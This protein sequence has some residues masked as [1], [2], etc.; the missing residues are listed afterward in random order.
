[1]VLF[2]IPFGVLVMED[3]YNTLCTHC[4]VLWVKLLGILRW[5]GHE[6]VRAELGWANLPSVAVEEL[7]GHV[8][9][10][11]SEEGD[12][13][14]TS[15]DLVAQVPHLSALLANIVG[16]AQ[17]GHLIA[18]FVLMCFNKGLELLVTKVVLSLPTHGLFLTI[19]FG[20]HD[21]VHFVAILVLEDLIAVHVI[22]NLTSATHLVILSLHLGGTLFI[23]RWKLSS[24]DDA[25]SELSLFLC[26]PAKLE[27]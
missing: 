25:R 23:E 14:L 7:D 24:I 20:V 11:L 26:L 1:M 3:L 19:G 27:G 5:C 12:C 9:S 8:G 2:G 18:S 4:E 22:S 16:C 10:I 13:L 15:L 6:V 21:I 17:L